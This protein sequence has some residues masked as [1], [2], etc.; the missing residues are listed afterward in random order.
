MLHV[1][2]AFKNIFHTIHWY[3]IGTYGGN[4]IILI[5]SNLY[6]AGLNIVLCSFVDGCFSSFCINY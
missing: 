5:K 2:E 6:I 3:G 1:K 4:G